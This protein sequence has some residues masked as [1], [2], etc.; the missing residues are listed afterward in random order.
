[1]T[2]STRKAESSW[3]ICSACRPRSLGAS[4]SRTLGAGPSRRAAKRQKSSAAA[5]RSSGEIAATSSAL[6]SSQIW[7]MKAAPADVAA[8]S[9]SACSSASRKA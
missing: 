6:R 3:T 9:P 8:S 2:L 4:A 5:A 1:M 7:S